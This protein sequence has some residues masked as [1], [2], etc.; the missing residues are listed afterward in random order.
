MAELK[1]CFPPEETD[2]RRPLTEVE[3][4]E[5]RMA[6]Q[7]IASLANVAHIY[8]LDAPADRAGESLGNL[9]GVFTVLQWLI[10][11]VEDYLFNYAGEEVAPKEKPEEKTA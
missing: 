1:L 11:P 3:I 4:T 5:I 6:A 7:G 10:R 9:T 2:K 8:A